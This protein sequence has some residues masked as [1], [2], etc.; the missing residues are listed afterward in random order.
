MSCNADVPHKNHSR[1]YTSAHGC[2][3]YHRLW[4]GNPIMGLFGMNL[5]PVFFHSPLHYCRGQG[6]G[7]IPP[8][9]WASQNS[10]LELQREIKISRFKGKKHW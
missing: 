2:D 8:G 5:T 7:G 3:R 10:P 4:Y 6:A 9:F 1:E